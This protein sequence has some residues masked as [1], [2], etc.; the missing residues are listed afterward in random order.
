M[1]QKTFDRLL[2]GL[3]SKLDVLA[4]NGIEISD[5]FIETK[6]NQI[7]EELKADG[8]ELGDQDIKSLIFAAG[9]RYNISVGEEGISVSNPD[10][11]R[12]LDS[13]KTELEWPH[14]EAYLRMLELKGRSRDL[15]RDTEKVIDDILD[16]SGDPSTPGSW[17]RKGLVMGNVQSGKT[18][19][20]IGLI[21]K[22]IDAGYK[23]IILLGGHLNDLRRQTQERVDEG[24]LGIESRHLA[25]T[26]SAQSKPIGVGL[27]RQNNVNSGTTTLGDFNKAFAGKLGFKLTGVDP[28]IFTVKKDTKVMARLHDW[29][30]DFHFLAPDSGKQL[31]GPLLLIDDEADYASIN[32]KHHKE[33]VTRTNEYIRKLL[34]LFS[35]STYVGYTA[36]PFAN[37]FIDP[38]HNE[39]SADD[40]LFPSDF[41]IKMPVAENY[42]GQDWFFGSESK[43]DDQQ[44]SADEYFNSPTVAID[45]YLPIYELKG[46]EDVKSLPESLKVAMQ[47]FLLVI[48]IRALRGGQYEHNTMLVNISHLQRHQDQLEV[49]MQEY[50]EEL[51]EAIIAFSG[52]GFEAARESSILAKM[53]KTFVTSFQV[54]EPYSQVFNKLKAAAAKVKVWAINQSAM[55]RDGRELDYNK[56]KDYGLSA[57][58]IGGHKLS[59]G[60]TLEGLSISYFARNSKAYDTLMQ[61]CRWFG[62]RP[63]YEDLV[64]VY[65]PQA[66]IE[67]YR[68]ITATIQELYR[69]L[70]V[71]RQ[72][73]KRPSEFGL[74]V[75]EHPG[76]MMI[77]ARNKVGWSDTTTRSQDLWGQVQ[78]RFQF[79]PDADVNRRNYEFARRFVHDL[80]VNGHFADS[81]SEETC[82]TY[83]D[84]PYKKIIDFINAMELPEDDLGNEALIRHLG[85]MESL[86]L[87]PPKVVLYNQTKSGR[88][89]WAADLS[90]SE[91][92]FL[93]TADLSFRPGTPIN[94]AK[95]RM[96]ADS[97]TGNIKV[98]SVHLGNPD[99]EKWFI[100]P[101]ARASVAFESGDKAPVSFDYLCSDERESPGLLIYLFGVACGAKKARKHFDDDDKAHFHLPFG[102]VPTVGFTVSIPRPENLKGKTKSE[103][104]TIVRQTKHQYRVG[105]VWDRLQK[106]SSYETYYD[107]E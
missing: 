62:Y 83:T 49:L 97:D 1:N 53:E 4:D 68:F 92:E 57:I 45:D 84:V 20:F 52:L 85:K 18:Q 21:N 36:T 90:D 103:I 61:M 29:I 22:A 66:S 98:S 46:H 87:K 82:I 15:L 28:V 60:L 71:M 106:L 69:E 50:L 6:V 37:I 25:E 19:N 56:Y 78:R 30:R 58:V 105:K 10:L 73:E 80:D 23:T 75:R 77:T 67:W 86:G 44:T 26:T 93:D 70:G 107:D 102:D 99:D 51:S 59:R 54:K 33:E 104:A 79:K 12:W 40:D 100:S 3:T 91:N 76:A 41:M 13:K 64:R 7:A 89:A 88:V 74:R 17:S 9:L 48:A 39:F 14:W 47:A 95:R 8:V 42:R 81:G 32:T 72:L 43:E 2:A 11:P 16:F 96:Y 38:D 31:P 27:I 63:G 5:A 35:R 65:L 101:S 94:L 34:K 24:V 55:S